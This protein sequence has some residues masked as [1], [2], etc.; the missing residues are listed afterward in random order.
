MTHFYS[1]QP[2]HFYSGVDA[3]SF[4][5]G[6]ET[7]YPL[8]TDEQGRDLLSTMIYG[9][10]VSIFVGVVGVLFA[11]GLGT[12][13]GLLSGYVG[14]IVDNVIT[15]VE[16]VL[17]ARTARASTIAERE[18]GYVKAARAAGVPTARIVFR[19]LL[20]NILAPVVVIANVR[21]PG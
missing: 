3:P 4:L 17:Y 15:A 12:L 6:G 9:A 7:A 5:A 1:G 8:G 19:H 11:A 10:R 20:P 13:L 2:I 16:W 18:R 21:S 14:G